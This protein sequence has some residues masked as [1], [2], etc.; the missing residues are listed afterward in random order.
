M[1]AS[2]ASQCARWVRRSL[3]VMQRRRRLPTD[4]RPAATSGLALLLGLCCALAPAASSAQASLPL[5]GLR[6]VFRDDPAQ[7]DLLDTARE[8]AG[9]LRMRYPP[10]AGRGGDPTQWTVRVGERDGAIRPRVTGREDLWEVRLGDEVAT[11]RT[12]FPRQFD[13]WSIE[14]GDRR[15]VFELR[16]PALLEYWRTRNFG[17][18]E[19]AYEVYTRFE[20]DP[21]EW[22]IWDTL[23]EPI[24][25]AAQLAMLWLPV[26]LRL[27][28]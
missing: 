15:I 5:S 1:T 20:G 7:W 3:S 25:A 9:E 10:V 26:Y 14:W 8:R 12:L 13:A 27:R 16:D 23:D 24:G 19:A 17:D 11:V 21:S 2:P 22:E 4:R 18:R 6:A 28:G